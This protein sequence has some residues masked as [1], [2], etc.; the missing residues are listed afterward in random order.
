MN[1]TSFRSFGLG[2]LFSVSLFGTAFYTLGQPPKEEKMTLKD[3]KKWLEEEQYIIL[4]EDELNKVKQEVKT[5]LE[6]VANKE[7]KSKEVPK[8]EIAE[9]ETPKSIVTYHLEVESGMT[10]RDIV[11]RLSKAKVISEPEKLQSYLDENNY[12]TQIQLGIFIITSE[13]NYE[14]IAK[15]ITKS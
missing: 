10:S 3:A 5:Q 13:M 14:Q 4:T 1:K 2:M 6:E 11:N 9:K 7:D 15:I 12:S 8:E